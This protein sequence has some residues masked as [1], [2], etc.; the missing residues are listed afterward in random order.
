V[1]LVSRQY[2][3][4]VCV[5]FGNSNPYLLVYYYMFR[6]FWFL[7]LKSFLPSDILYMSSEMIGSGVGASKGLGHLDYFC[8]SNAVQRQEEAGLLTIKTLKKII[9]EN[10]PNFPVQALSKKE[11]LDKI[12]PRICPSTEFI[13]AVNLLEYFNPVPDAEGK[14]EL[15]GQIATVTNKVKLA[16]GK[17]G[18]V[19]KVELTTPDGKKALLA[20]KIAFE[21][22]LDEAIIINE[23]AIA[24]ACP[25]VIPMKIG[26]YEG[27]P[28]LFMP[29][30]DGDLSK[31]LGTLTHRQAENI[32]NVLKNILLCLSE[33]GAYY[34]D[35]KPQNI[36]YHC[37]NATYSTIYL[38]DMASTVPTS[39]GEYIATHPPPVDT[40]GDMYQKSFSVFG[41]V[42]IRKGDGEPDKELA[43]KIYT[44]QLS[45]L[46]CWLITPDAAAPTFI[47]YSSTVKD[48]GLYYVELQ[49]FLEKYD[50]FTEKKNR[51]KYYETLQSMY[52]DT[53]MPLKWTLDNIVPL[54]DF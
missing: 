45:V 26:S 37:K 51:N 12:C 28:A 53:K 15:N 3:I 22:S 9:K 18:T 21:G 43:M 4:L 7:H 6:H 13:G 50:T 31:L 36:V 35:I 54:N 14:Y 25:G 19:Y 46:Y 23:N 49:N 10:Y 5:R 34:F 16:H 40:I 1:L 2:K 44:Y 32:I 29:L 38:T 42:S 11:L 8:N 48:A 41:Y 20:M 33:A 39:D 27:D 30:A 52:N 24:V 17:E 47:L